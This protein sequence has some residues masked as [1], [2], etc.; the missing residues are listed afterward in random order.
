MS[1]DALV[2]PALAALGL[3]LAL[4]VGVAAARKSL[5]NA[6]QARHARRLAEVRPGVLRMVGAATG[7]RS[8]LPHE[9]ASRA[10]VE[11]LAVSILPKLRGSDRAGLIELLEQ[12]GAIERAR[13]RSYRPGAVGRA[14]AI[15]LLGATGVPRA[16]PE[17]ARALRDRN[18][19]VR[20][21]A[22]RA[23]GKLG[24]PSAVPFLLAALEKPRPVPVSLIGMAL[25]RIGPVACPGLAAG[26]GA[27]SPR[28]RGVSVELLGQ[29][30][31]LPAVPEL[32]VLLMDDP[33]PGVRV[34]A[35]GALWRIGSPRALAPLTECLD[36][37]QP[38]ALRAAAARALGTVGPGASQD[39]L[40]VALWSGSHEVAR[41]AADTLC[42]GGPEAVRRLAVAAT[43]SGGGSPEA[44]EALV[45][46][47]GVEPRRRAA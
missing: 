32:I 36:A 40:L 30:G 34:R 15:E 1:A 4:L 46:R 11:E 42:R 44:R 33:D 45:E 16:L 3:M 17:V 18:P 14:K 38:P 29:F 22:A 12:G 8:D 19:D 35:A 24:D 7:S 27:P 28:A 26:L 47:A 43:P 23:L 37:S 25:A 39:A 6:A 10:T 5:R 31:A 9:G 20:A 41:A 21:V 13:R 2:V